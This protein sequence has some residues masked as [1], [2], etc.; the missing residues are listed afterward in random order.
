MNATFGYSYKLLITQIQKEFQKQMF[1]KYLINYVTLHIYT[2][3]TIF[4]L[5]HFKTQNNLCEI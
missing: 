5:K 2:V 1:V 4:L 3:T